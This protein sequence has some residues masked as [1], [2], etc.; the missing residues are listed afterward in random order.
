MSRKEM[1]V[2]WIVDKFAVVS[3]YHKVELNEKLRGILGKLTLYDLQVI[4]EYLHTI[5][6]EKKD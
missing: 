1:M 4:D 6:L 5:K 3:E 2:E